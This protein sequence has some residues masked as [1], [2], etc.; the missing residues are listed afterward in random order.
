V[1]L[2]N[3]DFDIAQVAA[4]LAVVLNIAVYSMRT[5][6]PL[7]IIALTT[8]ALFIVYAGM[9]GVFPTLILNCV[10]LPLNAYRLHQM[11]D[12][13][14]R[15][16][17]AAETE[18][19]MNWLKPFMSRQSVAAGTTLFRKGDSAD[20]MY[21]IAAGKFRLAESGLEIPAGSVVGEMGLFSPDG[22]RTQ[23]LLCEQEGEIFSIKYQ[24]FKQL[25]F[26]NPEFGFYF[27]QLTTKRLFE[28]IGRLEN[29]LAARDVL[30]PA[31]HVSGQSSP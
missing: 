20:A 17:R 15:I 18:F 10:L 3:F 6:I 11:L 14:R 31:S 13:I 1:N 4:A 29:T 24:D 19:D 28:N 25:Y 30:V 8:N 12:L 16:K 2:S 21:V 7:R 9:R 26:Q 22:Q 27:L 23:T 5:M